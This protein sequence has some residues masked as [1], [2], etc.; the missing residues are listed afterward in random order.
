MMKRERALAWGN[1]QRNGVSMID[2]K[3]PF[4]SR[5]RAISR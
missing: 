5:K 3:K 2:A 4:S 1:F